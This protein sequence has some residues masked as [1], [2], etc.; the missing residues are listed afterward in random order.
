MFVQK[1]RFCPWCDL[2]VA[3]NATVCASCGVGLTDD[4]PP[5]LN[6][7]LMDDEYPPSLS[8][9]LMADGPSSPSPARRRHSLALWLAPLLLPVIGGFGFHALALSTP[10]QA[11]TEAQTPALVHYSD[12]V[13]Q[14]VWMTGQAALR[15]TV[16]ETGDVHIVSSF[17]QRSA[18]N[19]LSLCGEVEQRQA[20][21]QMEDQH[22]VSMWGST[23]QT[24]LEMTNE[25]FPVLWQRLCVADSDNGQT[26]LNTSI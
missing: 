17:V 26:G 21:G 2:A 1:S 15:R 7:A 6:A 25:T 4:C 14:N 5:S 22:F 12:A 11:S 20:D 19:I 10:A 13:E 9:A 23:Q 16:G 3:R 18:G 8:P 24:V